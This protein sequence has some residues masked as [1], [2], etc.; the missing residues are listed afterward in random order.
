MTGRHYEDPLS[1]FY[2]HIETSNKE[3]SELYIRKVVND[4]RME[5]D[6]ILSD[7][8]V[9]DGHGNNYSGSREDAIRCFLNNFAVDMKVYLSLQESIN[10]VISEV[11]DTKKADF[12]EYAGRQIDGNEDAHKKKSWIS[13]IF[14]V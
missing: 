6:N 5:L 14:G 4:N 13:R 7:P 9:T 12:S 1:K 8:P 10:V 11:G 3:I 2:S